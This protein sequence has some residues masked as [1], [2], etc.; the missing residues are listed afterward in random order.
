VTITLPNHKTT[1][2]TV[3]YVG[4]V[5]TSSSSG[6]GGGGSSPTIEV[7]ITPAD[8]AATGTLDAAPVTVSIVTA[9][10]SNVLAVPVTALLAQADGSYAV[11]VVG[12]GSQRHLVPVTL[13]MFD[14]SDGLVEIQGEGLAAGQKVVVAGS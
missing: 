4:T 6:G 12:A 11:E 14:D 2:G 1:D 9:S 10:V 3:S 5:A 8:S 13:G 7:D